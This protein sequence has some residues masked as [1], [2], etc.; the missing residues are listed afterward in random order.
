[1]IKGHFPLQNI[2][3]RVTPPVISIARTSSRRKRKNS[4]LFFCKI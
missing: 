3:A 4:H 2:L 1:M